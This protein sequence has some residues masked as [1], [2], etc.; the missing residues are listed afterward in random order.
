MYWYITILH[1]FKWYIKRNKNTQQ[2]K[3]DIHL[4]SAVLCCHLLI[5][6]T[7][8]KLLWSRD[9]SGSWGRCNMLWSQRTC[10]HWCC[11]ISSA[12]AWLV[13]TWTTQVLSANRQL[14]LTPSPW[15]ISQLLQWWAP[16]TST[17]NLGEINTCR[18]ILP[19]VPLVIWTL[20]L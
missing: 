19:T 1:A 14:H 15:L 10:T 9:I 20:D 13:C 4:P 8:N 6:N 18:Q 11:C 3:Y 12:A 5:T 17:Q 2:L 16:I 7:L